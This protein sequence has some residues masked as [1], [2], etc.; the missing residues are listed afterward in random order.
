MLGAK[1]MAVQKLAEKDIWGAMRFASKA[2]SLFPGLEGVSQ[3]LETLD[4]YAASETKVNGEVDGYEI[5]GR[6]VWWDN[7]ENYRKLAVALYLDKNN[8]VG[9]NFKKSKK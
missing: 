6:C 3:F 8:A 4:I 1:E 2:Q 7:Q 9:L 5:H